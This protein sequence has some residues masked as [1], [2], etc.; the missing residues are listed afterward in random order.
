MT[1]THKKNKSLYRWQHVKYFL[2]ENLLHVQL[3][4]FNSVLHQPFNW[5]IPYSS[6]L[7]IL[8]QVCE[9]VTE[10]NWLLSVFLYT[11]FS[12]VEEEEKVFC[13]VQL[14]LPRLA[15]FESGQLPSRQ[16]GKCSQ[17][18]FIYANTPKPWVLRKVN[19]HLRL[20]YWQYKSQ[21]CLPAVLYQISEITWSPKTKHKVPRNRIYLSKVCGRFVSPSL[22]RGVCAFSIFDPAV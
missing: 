15:T 17:S 12:V 11:K 22:W 10:E 5:G 14:L 2:K 3:L 7:L 1:C 20:F 6:Y 8:M 19:A 18:T 16:M 13:S 4:T 21:L 9:G